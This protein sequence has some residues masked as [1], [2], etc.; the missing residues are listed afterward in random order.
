MESF[1]NKLEFPQKIDSTRRI[2]IPSQVWELMELETGQQVMVTIRIVP[3]RITPF[4]SV[5]YEPGD[6]VSGKPRPKPDGTESNV[7]WKE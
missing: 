5:V 1:E 2:R 3:K 7:E 6:M 4:Q